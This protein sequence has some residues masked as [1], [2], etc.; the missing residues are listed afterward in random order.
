MESGGKPKK[1]FSK[2]QL[3]AS[4]GLLTQQA[5]TNIYANQTAMTPFGAVRHG[6]DIRV[7]ELYEGDSDD[8]LTDEEDV[9]PTQT[10][11]RRAE[12][13]DDNKSAT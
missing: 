1:R 11:A 4:Q 7:R 8:F 10:R 6:A 3:R 5:R 2:K 12:K 13:N 9:K